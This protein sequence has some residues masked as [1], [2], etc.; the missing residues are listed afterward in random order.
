MLHNILS[1]SFFYQ[2]LHPLDF[3]PAQQCKQLLY[4]AA[5]D[6][7]ESI[8]LLHIHLSYIFAHQSAF[9]IQEAHNVHLVQLSFLPLPIY[10]VVQRGLAGFGVCS[11]NSNTESSSG[12]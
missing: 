3:F 9:L 1:T 5:A 10:K 6:C 4:F 8:V 2:R 12:R 7:H 11:G